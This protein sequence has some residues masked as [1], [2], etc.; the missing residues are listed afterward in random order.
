MSSRGCPVINDRED[1]NG[2]DAG[3]HMFSVVGFD[4]G[5]SI[6]R[7][8]EFVAVIAISTIYL[9]HLI[10]NYSYIVHAQLIS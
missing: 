10:L 2:E 3:L 5:G 4:S 8:M 9:I 6:G 7:L 1:R